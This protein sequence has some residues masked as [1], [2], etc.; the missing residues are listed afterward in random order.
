MTR[1]R[2]ASGNDPLDLVLGGGLPAN[3]INLLIGRP[4]TGKTIIAQQYV[5]KN[6]TPELPSVYFATVSEP[7]EKILRFGQSLKFFDPAAIGTSVFYEDLGEILNNQGLDGVAE[8]IGSV[9]RNRR[10]G[11]IVIDSFKALG[12]FA[13]T[14]GDFR[15]FLHALAGRLSA[16]TAAA[17][18]VGEYDDADVSTGPEFAV[19]DA[20]VSLRTVRTGEREVR[21]LQVVKLRGSDFLSGRHTY[22]LSSEGLR[23]FPRL[24]DTPADEQYVL[25][26]PR[27]SSGIVAL[28]HMLAQGYWPGS[29]T[30]V[31]GPSGSGKT[32]MGLHFIFNG[33][34]LGEPGIV[35]TL[36]EN[37]IQLQR[38]VDGFGWSLNEPG[39]EVMYRSPVDVYVDEW[40]YDLLRLAKTSGARRILLDSLPDLRMTTGDEVRF[41]EFLYSLMQRCSRAGISLMMTMEIP[42]LFG[43]ER[44]SEFGISHLSDNVVLLNYFI[45]RGS[46]KRA[47]SVTKTRASRHE[48]EIREFSI[49]PEGIVLGDVVR[50]GMTLGL[51]RHSFR[52]E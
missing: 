42:E 17:L 6:G 34:R 28:D 46:I 47:M 12:A 33:A 11:L 21:F 15:R 5:F 14:S 40:V 23:L 37:P 13:E 35:A 29:S 16:S 3:A 39:V 1:N 20:I 52:P 22:R 2:L 25:Q 31:A 26:G 10:P 36:Q 51:G 19:A 50:T 43:V 49:E 30:L 7:L 45:D 38:I 48:Q 41:R 24:A 8:R 9:L 4:G 32:L 18:W 44:F 27:L